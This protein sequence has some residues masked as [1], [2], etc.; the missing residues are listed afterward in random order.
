MTVLIAN[1]LTLVGSVILTLSGLTK[2]KRGF[3]LS[4][5]GMNVLFITSNV[6]LGGYSGAVVNGV[7]LCRNLTTCKG[8]LTKPV[9][10]V[11]ILIQIGL[12]AM[13][14]TGSVIMWLPVI[15]NSVFTWIMDTEDMVFL[16]SVFAST[17]IIWALYDFHI[18][19]YA[20]VPFDI[21]AALTSLIA[22]ARELKARKDVSAD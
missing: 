13:F 15:G 17:Q 11:I 9:K 4:Q 6:L 10:V 1:I 20:G 22:I 16:K 8:R 5:C 21:A 18:K 3:L 7:N 14:G 19:N 12:T 2:K